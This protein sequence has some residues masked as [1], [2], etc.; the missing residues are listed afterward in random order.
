MFQIANK[1]I[2]KN[3][4]ICYT[5]RKEAIFLPKTMKKGG[6]LCRHPRL[7]ARTT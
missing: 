1:T 5:F 2:E 4:K 7:G 3:Q 6:A